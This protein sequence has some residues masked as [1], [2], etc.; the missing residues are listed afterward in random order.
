VIA[1][2]AGVMLAKLLI[3]FGECSERFLVS[4]LDERDEA[5]PT[6]MRTYDAQL[7]GSFSP[8]PRGSTPRRICVTTASPISQPAGRPAP[9]AGSGNAGPAPP[10]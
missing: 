3:H 6:P 1:A 7:G 8:P 10:G 2:L 4:H 5:A 9:S